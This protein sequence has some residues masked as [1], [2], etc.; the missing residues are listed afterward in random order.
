MEPSRKDP[1]VIKDKQAIRGKKL[2]KVGE[3]MV[4]EA[5]AQ[6]INH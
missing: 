2:N 5:P 1:G 4:R 6:T 3:T